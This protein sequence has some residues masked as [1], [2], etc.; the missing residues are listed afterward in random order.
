MASIQELRKR[1]EFWLTE[2]G[3][4]ET[5]RRASKVYGATLKD[6]KET[7]YWDDSDKRLLDQIIRLIMNIE[8]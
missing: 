3:A 4:M 7:K 5:L 1:V 6:R 8:Q 2:P